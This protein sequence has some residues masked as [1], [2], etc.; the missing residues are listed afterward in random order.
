YD[1]R[2]INITLPSLNYWGFVVINMPETSPS[3]FEVSNLHVNPDT[4]KVGQ[5]A[6][7]SVS[8]KNNGGE[9]GSCVLTLNI[10]GLVV[11]TRTVKLN[12]GQSTTVSFTYT[13]EKEGIYSIEINGLTGSLTVSR[14]ETPGVVSETIWLAI[15]IVAIV[16]VTLATIFFRKPCRKSS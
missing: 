12:P 4:I 11:D 6:L 5:A 2:Y 9:T 16:A 7:I 10:N 14:E 3:E 13:P 8:V 15:E 1:G